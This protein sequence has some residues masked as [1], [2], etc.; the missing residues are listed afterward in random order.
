MFFNYK[1]SKPILKKSYERKK[2]KNMINNYNNNQRN[3]YLNFFN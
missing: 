2:N 1:N 3:N